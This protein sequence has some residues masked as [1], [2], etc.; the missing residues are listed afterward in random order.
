M[1]AVEASSVMLN[2]TILGLSEDSRLIREGY[3]F[4]ALSG[5]QADGA[6]F[7]DDAIHRGAKVILTSESSL[8]LRDDVSILY[9]ENPRKRLSQIA[10]EFF[11]FQPSHIAA[12]T[13]TNGKSSVAEFC[14]QIWSLS[15]YNSA[16][17]GTLGVH[18]KQ[19]N[20]PLNHTTPS[21]VSVYEILRDLYQVGVTHLAME[22]SSHGLAQY[23]MDDVQVKVAGF[24]N[25]TRD[26]LDYHKSES[27]YLRAKSRLFTDILAEDGI[28]VLNG[29]GHGVDAIRPV[30]D[31][32][33]HCFVIGSKEDCDLQIRDVKSCAD[34]IEFELTFERQTVSV[35]CPVFGLFQAENIALAVG[36][37]LGLGIDFEII[38]ESLS[39]LHAPKGRMEKVV[40]YQGGVAYVDYAHTPDALQTV[41][42]NLRLHCTGRL[43]CVFGCGGNRDSG[44][45]SQ[46]GVVAAKYADKVIITDDN[47]R[48]EEA[49]F[50]RQDI[51]QAC[52]QGVEIGDR[53]EAIAFGLEDLG[54]GDILLIAGK[55]HETGQ[56]IGD[57]ILPFSDQET[58]KTMVSQKGSCDV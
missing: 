39:Q 54:S 19:F 27:E 22:A 44:K 23:R 24:T 2:K 56:I 14:S 55:G 7:I 38:I 10:S 1:M 46:M 13:G 16:S 50:I 37:S 9:D 3:L 58:L 43:I 51:L 34:G 8:N 41:L 30:M 25:F 28:A 52:S 21:S 33:R 40:S 5:T 32:L 36:I 53:A 4:A 20:I 47:P 49:G 12:I 57:E 15:G 45:R 35:F 17:L 42:M 48:N 6:E 11:A 29:F 18:S 26:H 31:K